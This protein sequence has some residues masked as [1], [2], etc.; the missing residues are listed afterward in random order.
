MLAACSL[1][2]LRFVKGRPMTTV[3]YFKFSTLVTL[4]SLFPIHTMRLLSFFSPSFFLSAFSWVSFFSPSTVYVFQGY[5]NEAERRQGLW[6]IGVMCIRLRFGGKAH[7]IQSSCGIAYLCNRL[8]DI[9]SFS[10]KLLLRYLRYWQ[11]W[12]PVNKEKMG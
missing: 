9:L 2:I 12:R 11:H 3:A 7:T 10:K 6:I 1:P 8:F 4:C 5:F